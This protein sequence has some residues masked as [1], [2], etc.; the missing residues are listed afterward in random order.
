M[1]VTIVCTSI[2][3]CF[4]RVVVSVLGY[5]CLTIVGVS[6]LGYTCL[7]IVGVSA[8]GNTCLTI[9]G[10]S[11]LGFTCLTIVGVSVLGSPISTDRAGV[12]TVRGI[13]QA[14]MNFFQLL[15]L[16]YILQL[17][18]L[19]KLVYL[20]K[21]VHTTPETLAS[22]ALPKILTS[23]AHFSPPAPPVLCTERKFKG[24]I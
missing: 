1:C 10:V 18:N 12:G 11:V 9:V 21:P 2:N 15:N 8:I 16:L 13:L 4:T 24:C 14:I 5:T 19:L 17:L 22:P 23:F 3:M 7:T 6:L 20:L